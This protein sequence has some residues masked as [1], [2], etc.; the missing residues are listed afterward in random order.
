MSDV[1]TGQVR[2]LRCKQANADIAPCVQMLFPPIRL[3]LCPPTKRWFQPPPQLSPGK[4]TPKADSSRGVQQLCD[5]QTHTDIPVTFYRCRSI[6]HRRYRPPKV[7][8]DHQRNKLCRPT[9][10]AAHLFTDM[11]V[12]A[13]GTGHS[14]IH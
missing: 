11:A 14:S 1:C 6:M 10:P 9:T 4:S 5:L 13:T 8:S 7:L 2:T 3:V 12:Y